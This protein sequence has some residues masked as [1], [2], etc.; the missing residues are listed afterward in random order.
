MIAGG[1]V[2]LLLGVAAERRG[3]EQVARP[4]SA[5]TDTQV[6]RAPLPKAHYSPSLYQG[7]S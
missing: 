1:I 3:L 6:P 5:V 2:E 4:L 7:E